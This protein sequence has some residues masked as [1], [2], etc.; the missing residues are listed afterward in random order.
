MSTIGKL[1]APLFTAG[2]LL[3]I[4]AGVILWSPPNTAIAALAAQDETVETVPVA[5]GVKPLGN[6]FVRA[7]HFDNPS[8]TWLWYDPD[9]RSLS[10]L[11]EFKKGQPYYILVTEDT[12]LVTLS[13]GADNPHRLTCRGSGANRNCWNNIGW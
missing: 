8:K 10:T 11:K 7:F 3:A 2:A 9:V 6:K 12:T 1:L 5:E 13:R 4:A